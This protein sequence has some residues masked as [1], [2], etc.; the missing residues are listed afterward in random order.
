MLVLG[1]KRLP[2]QNIKII[3][4]GG[5]HFSQLK[6]PKDIEIKL[7]NQEHHDEYRLAKKNLPNVGDLVKRKSIIY[8][9]KAKSEDYKFS[10]EFK[11]K[12]LSI[13]LMPLFL[14]EN[15]NKYSEW[16]DHE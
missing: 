14:K 11:L 10:K 2:Y 7:L 4:D 5:W 1:P 13:D 15:I 12:R 3:E 6:T 16:F 8:D 9:H